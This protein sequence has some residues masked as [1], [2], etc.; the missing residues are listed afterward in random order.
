MEEELPKRYQEPKHLRRQLERQRITESKLEARIWRLTKE[1]EEALRNGNRGV[2]YNLCNE[3]AQ[4][5]RKL[6]TTL[7]HSQYLNGKI[8]SPRQTSESQRL[9]YSGCTGFID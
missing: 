8:N 6:A 3:A 1:I 9:D 2:A 5:H 4:L 7:Y